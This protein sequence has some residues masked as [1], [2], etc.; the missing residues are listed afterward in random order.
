MATTAQPSRILR[1]LGAVLV[2]IGLAML[3]GGVALIVVGG[4]WFYP[5][6]G[7]GFAGTGVLVWRGA[8]A[9]LEAYAV[10]L[11]AMLVWALS[12]VGL[13]W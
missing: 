11:A 6:V 10:T 9:A 5:V 3:A 7:L 8:S 2:L 13:D 4:S 12:E 1:A